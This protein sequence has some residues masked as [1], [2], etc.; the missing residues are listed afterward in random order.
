[1]DEVIL[2]FN[3]YC[4]DRS[5]LFECMSNFTESIKYYFEV[6]DFELHESVHAIFK[7]LIDHA[8][9]DDG[10]TLIKLKETSVNACFKTTRSEISKCLNEKTGN[11]LTRNVDQFFHNMKT[12][13]C[14]N[15]IEA[16]REVQNCTVN[17]MKPCSDFLS[18]VIDF[19]F[20]IVYDNFRRDERNL[21]IH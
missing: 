15:R 4:L 20:N 9:L 1:M 13:E 19:I 21:C 2:I 16:L 14:A 8:C 17:E 7:S 11:F 3:D 18:G 6:D 12:I 5:D 10:A